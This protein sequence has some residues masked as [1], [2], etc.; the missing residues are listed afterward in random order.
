MSVTDLM[1][2]ARYGDLKG[3][4][5]NLNQ[6]GKQGGYGETA[7]MWAVINGHANCIPLLE[8][9]FGM[10]DK[11][12]CTALI[13]AALYGQ[14][15]SVRHLLSEA[16]KQTT[17][18]WDRFPSGTTALMMA[19]YCNRSDIVQLLLPY[20]QGLTDSKG[21]TAKWYAHNSSKEGDFTRVR[22]LLENE[23]TER[24]P[25]PR[26]ECLL[27]ASAVTGDI[28]GIKKHLDHVG[29]QDPTG[30]T[31]LMMAAKYGHSDCIPFL[32]KEIGMQNN[33]GRTA[34]M[35]A[36]LTGK[37]DCI[38]LLKEKV[39]KKNKIG[40]TALMMAALKGHINCIPLL[41]KEIGMQNSWGWT[42]LM[43]AARDG[44][45]DCVRLLLCE[46][47]KQTTKE[48][49]TTL[50][51]TKLTFPSGT[52]ALMIA[53][54]QNY[55]KIV[56]LL[57]PYEQGL[58]DSK[59]HT[60]HWHANNGDPNRGDF[61]CVRK[62]LENEGTIRLPPPSDPTEILKFLERVDKL[63]TENESLKKELSQLNREV[64]FLKQQLQKA[65]EENDILHEQFED[66]GRQDNTRIDQLTAE[67]SS[68]KQQLDNAIDESKR[69]AEMNEDLRKAS[70]QNRALINSL[71]TEKAALQEQ[72]SK[73]TEDLKRALADQ[74]ARILALEKEVTQLR[75]EGHDMKDLRRRLEEVEE[76]KRI[77][78][79]NLAAVGG[80]LTNHPQG[81]GTPTG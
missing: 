53:A 3:V 23:G 77:L 46:A 67:V 75:T 30:T 50:N 13:W 57:L 4:K 22:E 26:E 70:D 62:L 55:P 28:E 16:G 63:T 11:Y 32:E 49:V 5:R 51:D 42:A 64:S 58:K 65:N 21:H 33:D 35:K 52:T 19:A 31:A 59:G 61:T 39:G 80:R 73:T 69:H 40:M 1:R 37:A 20:E 44:K 7:L 25:P 2:A 45:T 29:Y 43:Y 12:G 47:G 18:E 81:L 36:A 9:D 6:V 41:E 27:V 60:A 8:N 71:T 54:Y 56:E 38:P 68:L 34:L 14:T 66:K 17:K 48:R 79:Q 72:L 15:D 74:K 24:V 76:E 78:L 10:Q